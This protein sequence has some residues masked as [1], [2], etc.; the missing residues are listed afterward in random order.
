[1]VTNDA[2]NVLLVEDDP[3]Q[4]RLV[5]RVL[6]NQNEQVKYDVEMAG[7][8]ATA[9][10]LLKE[11][12]FDNVL[13]D[14]QLP[15]SSG[16]K[17]V[18]AIRAIDPDIPIVVLSAITD[19]KMCFEAVRSGADYYLVKGDFVRDVLCRS[20]SYSIEHRRQQNGI[21]RL[22]SKLQQENEKIK[23]RLRQVSEELADKSEQ[24]DFVDKLLGR[25]RS[26]FITIFDSVPAVI[27]Y[28]DKEGKILRANKAA[29]DSV[30]LSPKEVVGRN[31]YELFSEGA[32]TARKKDLDVIQTGKPKTGDIREYKTSDGL[33]KYIQVD[34]IPYYNGNGEIAGVIVF[35]LDITDRKIADDNLLDAKLELEQLNSQLTDAVKNSQES[36]RKEMLANKAKSQFVA[37]VSHE[38]RT[39]VNAILGFAGLLEDDILTK[40]QQRCVHMIKVAGSN[41]LELVNDILDL[42]K[43]EAGKLDIE[44][45]NCRLADMI[46]E[47]LCLV[48]ADARAKGLEL[49]ISSHGK[50]PAFVKT[51]PI[52]VR[53]CLLNLVANAVKFTDQG[54]VS[55]IVS[56]QQGDAGQWLRLDVKDTGIGI[57]EDRQE[58]IFAAF[59]QAEISTTR[60]FGGTGLGLSITSKLVKL[61]G[62]TIEL[63][64]RIGEGSTF[65]I[66]LPFECDYEQGLFNADEIVGMTDHMPIQVCESDDR[67]RQRELPD[68]QSG[69]IV[70]ELSD[71]S[72][73]GQLIEDLAL[74]LP[75]IGTT[76]CDASQ[77]GDLS[78]LMK[79]ADVLTDA[80]KSAGYPVLA[81]KAVLL[82]KHAVD[83]H[84]DMA[85]KVALELEDICNRIAQGCSL[86]SN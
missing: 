38:V 67:S 80:G 46:E 74:K 37:G 75:R 47:V 63:S 23:L 18:E 61:L 28:R 32:D 14:L 78:L 73:Y 48:S 3:G 26:E 1:M 16:A 4:R 50:V 84:V 45:I 85:K 52:R 21:D 8:L 10:K 51:D 62:G 22:D 77:R 60:K 79:L 6:L 53:Q 29:A 58:A 40:T 31:Y 64:S 35:A 71:L 59:S 33:T 39:P 66:L 42:A 20:I 76:I 44:V 65:S 12:R 54:S 17:T 49:K 11:K 55:I 9:A 43:V 34:R 15:D 2:I 27:W 86:S 36:A 41:M 57:P 24:F 7:D 30:G 70:S 19:P 25:V 56:E 83:E 69:P 5:E 82:Q 13:L 81:E 68:T 72:E